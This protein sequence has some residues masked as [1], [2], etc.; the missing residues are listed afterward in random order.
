V[1][2]VKSKIFT[3]IQNPLA[4]RS[5]GEASESAL[6]AAF[7]TTGDDIIMRTKPKSPPSPTP[8]IIEQQELWKDGDCMWKAKTWGQGVLWQNYYAAEY[9]AGRT[10]KTATTKTTTANQ[11]IPP[12]D[13]GKVAYFMSHALRYDLLDYLLDFLESGW[14]VVSVEE[15]AEA[16]EVVVGLT[17]PNELTEAVIYQEPYPLPRNY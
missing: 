10:I 7:Y 3:A 13:M 4:G 16:W 14:L 9:R 5:H 15:K 6:T 12:K 2:K 8:P 17:N 1:A 11:Q